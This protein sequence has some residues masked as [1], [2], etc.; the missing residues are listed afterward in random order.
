MG[1]INSAPAK[2]KKKGGRFGFITKRLHNPATHFVGKVGHDLADVAA[3]VP[4]GLYGVGHGLGKDAY[5]DI[6][7]GGILRPKGLISKSGRKTRSG[8]LVIGMGHGLYEDFRHPLRRPGYTILDVL[9]GVGAAGKVGRLGRAS[10]ATKPR[11]RYITHKSKS[12]EEEKLIARAKG[13]KPGPVGKT[14][15]IPVPLA[16]S[17]VAKGAQKLGDATRNKTGRTKGKFHREL[18][19]EKQI[20]D[21][22]SQHPEAGFKGAV[23]QAV[24]GEKAGV[25]PSHQHPIRETNALVRALRL[26]RPGYIV[27]NAAGSIVANMTHGSFKTRYAKQAHRLRKSPEF[28]GKGSPHVLMGGGVSEAAADLGIK[29]GQK[30]GRIE[31]AARGVGES[32]G[33]ITDRPARVRS[34]L[35][36]VENQGY[37]S[38]AEV[39]RLLKRMHAGDPAAIDDIVQI[40][41]RAEPEAIKFSKTPGGKLGKADAALARNI[42]LYRWFEASTRYAGRTVAHHPAKTAIA[43][44][45]GRQGPDISDAISKYPD[46]MASLLPVGVRDKMPL[47]S[48]TQSFSLWDSPSTIQDMVTDPFG[49]GISQLNPVQ[50]GA[51]AA[52]AQKNFFTGQE[53]K[54]G[55]GPGGKVTPLDR[56]LFAINTQVAGSPYAQFNPVPLGKARGGKYPLYALPRGHFF[57]SK[58]KREKRLYPRTR[59]DIIGN[60]LLGS[61]YPGTPVN[62]KVAA[63]IRGA[64]KHKRRRRP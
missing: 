23:G 47:T 36:E 26:Y 61:G 48:G 12:V 37:K 50:A 29:A 11:V 14:H 17:P 42:F 54:H 25:D 38:D 59:E 44:G 8:R 64:K 63:K 57:D 35:K 13:I 51:A 15:R 62:P 27:P 32:A 7:H 18:R 4:S 6:R 1:R 20:V 58:E 10:A 16:T 33:K 31:T 56:L 53:I 46:W 21:R 60:F 28:K 41:R 9:G 45:L 43:A 19:R 22:I 3:H 40:I 34:F 55:T 2:K 52:A 30:V 24:R 5:D 49:R 39:T